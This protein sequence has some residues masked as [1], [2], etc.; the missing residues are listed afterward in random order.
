MS[1]GATSAFAEDLLRAPAGVA[2]LARLE[3]EQRADQPW[4]KSPTASDH[5]A[6]RRAATNIGEVSFAKLLS[7][8]TWSAE[9]WAGP[10]S[11][12]ALSS[13]PYLYK[14]ALSRRPIA[15]AV[16]DRFSLQL[17]R[18]IDLNAQQWWHEDT[19]DM[20]SAID[21]CFTDYSHVYGNGEFTWSGLWT[22][23]DPPPEV[24]DDL[25]SAWDYFG[26][27]RAGYFPCVATRECGTS[28]I[29]GTGH[30]WWRLIRRWSLDHILVG[31]CLVQTNTRPTQ[32]C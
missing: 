14:D 13:L 25:I 21:P 24:H 28:T 6:V 17:H 3:I 19:K 9:F 10:W 7:M 30:G 11:G 18:A 2:L 8:A 12:Q 23:T 15:E 26:Q 27:L 20:K 16:A 29:P 4:F 32:K 22:V 31:S 5:E 1:F